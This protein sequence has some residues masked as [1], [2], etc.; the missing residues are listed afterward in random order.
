LEN[1]DAPPIHGSLITGTVGLATTLGPPQSPVEVATRLSTDATPQLLLSAPAEYAGEAVREIRMDLGEGVRGVLGHLPTGWTGT[2]KEGRAVFSGPAIQA[3]RLLARIDLQGLIQAPD[4]AVSL[5]VAGRSLLDL[6]SSI[7]RLPPLRILTDLEDVLHFPWN[8]SPGEVVR[9]QVADMSLTP[10]GGFWEIAGTPL[11]PA[12]MAE[13]GA[14]RFVMSIPETLGAD[15]PL[16]VRWTDPYGELVVDIP[17]AGVRISDAPEPPNPAPVLEDCAP[18]GFQN[19]VICVCGYFPTPESQEGLLLDG[20]PMGSPVGAS[21]HTLMVRIPPGTP[22]G[23]H[24]IT[25]SREAGF[26]GRG[27]A[28]VVVLSVQGQVDQERLSLGQVTP[29]RLQIQGETDPLEIVLTNRDPTTVDVVGGVVQTLTTSGGSPNTAATQVRGISPGAFAIHY[30]LAVDPCPCAGE[31][32]PVRYAEDPPPEDPEPPTRPESDS[33]TTRPPESDSTRVPPQRPEEPPPDSLPVPGKDSI[34]RNE[35]E[36]EPCCGFLKDG[37]IS[38]PNI[39]DPMIPAEV[40][41]APRDAAV[42]GF[43]VLLHSGAYFHNELDLQVEAVGLPFRLARHYKGDVGTTAGGLMGSRW[44]H[45]L[46]KRIVPEASQ[47]LGNGLRRERAGFEPARL[48]YFDGQGGGSLYEGPSSEWREVLNFAKAQEFRAFVTTFTPHAGDFFEIQRYV[49]EDPSEHPFIDHPDVDRDHG[50]AI[51]YVLRERNGIRYVFNCRGQLILI[52]HRNDITSLAGTGVRQDADSVRITLEYGGPIN[53]LTQNTTLTQVEDP[54]G[55]KYTFKTDPMGNAALDTNIECTHRTGTR[56]IPRLTEVHAAGRLIR[57]VYGYGGAG[58]PVLASVSDSAAGG[59]RI[60]GYGYDAED[61]LVSVTSPKQVASDGIPHLLNRYDGAGRVIGQI[62]GDS[63]STE[64]T[65]IG[66]SYGADAATVTNSKGERTEYHLEKVSGYPVV[67]TETVHGGEGDEETRWTTTYAHNAHTQVDTIRYPAGNL[68]IFGF[69]GEDG[70]VTEGWIR[71]KSSRVTYANDLSA[72]NL[73]SVTRESGEVGDG[74]SV[75]TA[76]SYEPLFNQIASQTDARGNTTTYHYD[77]RRVG[78]LGNPERTKL[79]DIT[80]PDGIR[81]TVPATEYEYNVVGQRTRSENAGERVMTWS[82][83][84]VGYLASETFPSGAT[85]TFTRDRQGRLLRQSGDFEDVQFVLSGFGEVLRE[86]QDPDGFA[87]V[88][89]YRYDLDGGL[90]ESL[91]ELKDNF[92]HGSGT[93]PASPS[94]WVS[95]RT[96]RDIIGRVIREVQSSSAD[97]M[98]V[99]YGFDA[100]GQMVW[101]TNPGPN[102]TRIE[103]R[104][105]HDARGLVT[106]VRFAAGTLQE[107]ITRRSFDAN[108]NEIR[109]EEAAVGR[110]EGMDPGPPRITLYEYDGMDRLIATTDPL[111]ARTQRTLDAD[112]NPIRQTVAEGQGVPLSLTERV[113]DELGNLTSESHHVLDAAGTVAKSEIYLNGFL[114]RVRTVG[115]AGGV[116]LYRYD[117]GGRVDRVVTPSGD[118]TFTA[119]DRPGNRTEVR[120]VEIGERM[121]SSGASVPTH[122]VS[123]VKYE[124]DALGRVQREASTLHDVRFF[125]DSSRHLRGSLLGDGTADS[126]RYDG[127]GRKVAHGAGSITRRYQYGT[128][129][130]PVRM[131]DGTSEVEWTLDVH[132]RVVEER[133]T[134]SGRTVMV[135]D[136]LGNPL[137]VTDANGTAITSTFNEVGLPVTQTIQTTGMAF[138]SGTQVVVAPGRIQWFYDVLGRVTEGRSDDVITRLDYDGLGRVTLEEQE[139]DGQQYIFQKEYGPDQRS[140][141]TT[142]PEQAGSLQVKHRLDVLGRIETVHADGA[143]IARYTYGGPTRVSGRLYTNGILTRYSLDERGRLGRIDVGSTIGEGSTL[144]TNTVDYGRYGIERMQERWTSGSGREGQTTTSMAFDS[145]GQVIR[146]STLSIAGPEAS[147]TTRSRNTRYHEFSDGLMVRSGETL[148]DD[149]ARETRFTRADTYTYDSLGRK[150]GIDVTI[151]TKIPTPNQL[152]GGVPEISREAEASD[153]R[154]AG[155][156]EFLYDERGNLISDG[157]LYYSYDHMGRLTWVESRYAP[158]E[159][160]EAVHFL[161]DAFGRRVRAFPLEGPSATGLVSWSSWAREPSHYLYDGDQV[162]AEVAPIWSGNQ[163]GGLKRRYLLGPRP[164]ERI[165]AEEFGVDGD[166][167]VVYP[168]ESV[169]STVGF[170][171]DEVGRPVS[172]ASSS[173][174]GGAGFSV[175]DDLRFLQGTRARAPYLSWSTRVD[176]F[177]GIKYDEIGGTTQIDFRSVRAFA[178]SAAMRAVRENVASTMNDGALVLGAASTTLVAG[179]VGAAALT[180][181]AAQ[182]TWSGVATSVGLSSALESLGGAAIAWYT[183]DPTYGPQTFFRDAGTGA[184]FGLLGARMTAAGWRISQAMAAEQVIQNAITT[185]TG[186][187]LEGR[188]I[189]EAWTLAL[190]AS[191]TEMVLGVGLISV[192]RGAKALGVRL[193]RRAAPR[194]QG[195]GLGGKAVQVSATGANVEWGRLRGAWKRGLFRAATGVGRKWKYRMEVMLTM[196]ES[197]TAASRVAA[198]A[199][200]DGRVRV[201]FFHHT[202]ANVRGFV[203][204]KKPGYIYIN[205]KYMDRLPDGGGGLEHVASTMVHEVMHS[206]GGGEIAAHVAQAQFMAYRLWKARA[207]TWSR[208]DRRRAPWL[209]DHDVNMVRAWWRGR[210][211]GQFEDLVGVISKVGYGKRYLIQSRNRYSSRIRSAGGFSRLLGVDGRWAQSRAVSLNPVPAVGHWD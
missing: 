57:Y 75:T 193:L 98:V 89:E 81:V 153:D 65:R 192:A 208:F 87:N 16:P 114:E 84:T 27:S 118:T 42:G 160:G 161:Y 113:F 48:W 10:S 108:G 1:G 145:L 80:Q 110:P 55:A 73:I 137:R 62:L 115:P 129:G 148:F 143:W 209:R 5:G 95:S 151:G 33:T 150:V 131:S 173:P 14:E 85:R 90:I 32:P 12:G 35:E 206:L 198:Q 201:R 177:A 163:A 146:S 43:Q 101:E 104:Y 135:R 52:L 196:M 162:V 164:G 40:P 28:S 202:G 191:A 165:R 59:I 4:V 141:T 185:G 170:V 195:S 125:Y 154:L 63:A 207:L 46:N 70:P 105:Q 190:A 7:E 117:A 194:G 127:L 34:P 138:P 37:S 142:Y 93:P 184:L 188:G 126:I 180:S 120:Q 181:G 3:E 111:G 204:N 96:D 147:P 51:F 109:T 60:T 106:E 15:D 107:V 29:L 189:G 124:Y 121:D 91:Q 197:G 94:R 134:G 174:A 69:D 79:P 23:R 71:N 56:P 86:I 99:E 74:L 175:P 24:T 61:R 132:G 136:G 169:Q 77:Y 49:L 39:T 186:V 66:L 76:R 203:L 36:E 128:D 8:V 100:T 159:R 158:G 67:R 122:A 152:L 53:P 179:M 176:G 11:E 187:A 200:K 149:L 130:L 102:G 21:A 26:S 139:V 6:R 199:I 31:G 17:D 123:S 78:Y 103:D 20:E 54:T 171:T 41:V 116:A 88:T 168:H 172:I 133:R 183:D 58:D 205:A 211:T 72:G 19:R 2:L 13:N 82:Y 112:G 38:F 9:F 18:A 157:E 140:L 68:V 210:V 182:L 22:P 30:K 92:V 25:G 83:D 45:S 144:W 50:E 44:D 97:S 167:L 155:R 64:A 166:P 178:D 156:K 119:Y 47:D